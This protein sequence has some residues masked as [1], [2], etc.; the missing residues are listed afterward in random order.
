MTEIPPV[1]TPIMN[2]YPLMDKYVAKIE[3]D[4]KDFTNK[5]SVT[6]V[7][8][9]ET[10]VIL[11]RSPSM[12]N[13]FRFLANFIVPYALG[14]LGYGDDDPIHF[15]TFDYNAEYRL[16]SKDKLLNTQMECRGYTTNMGDAIKK[17]ESVMKL[18]KKNNIRI[19]V[20]SDGEVMDQSTTLMRASKISHLFEEKNVS[21]RAIRFITSDTGA[22]DTRAIS[23]VLQYNT[24][25]D[26]ALV[27]VKAKG[28]HA[29]EIGST[30]QSLFVDDGLDNTTKLEIGGNLIRTEPWKNTSESIYLKKGTNVFWL[31]K[32]PLQATIKTN[33]GSDINYKVRIHD[34]IKSL[35]FDGVLGDKLQ[36]L[37]Q[38]M[39]LYKVVNTPE[40]L[41]EIKTMVGYF[42]RLDDHCKRYDPEL[43]DPT[44]DTSLS[45]RLTYFRGLIKKKE[46]SILNTMLNIAGDNRVNA[47]NSSQQAGYLRQ[48]TNDK[49]GKQ[50]AKR[51]T[52][53]GL[54]LDGIARKEA[55]AI[56]DHFDEL[57]DMDCDDHYKSFY[58]QATTYDGLETVHDAV[59]DG[60]IDEM[61][62]NDILQLLNIVGLPCVAKIGD[63]PDPM[64]YRTQKIIK[65]SFASISDLIVNLECNRK[66]LDPIHKEEIV[67]VIPI[68]DDIEIYNFIK[69]YAP[70]LLEYT[71][72]IGMRRMI[73]DVPF[74]FVHTV[75]SGLWILTEELHNN[76]IDLNFDLFEKLLKPFVQSA[77]PLFDWVTPFLKDQDPKLSYYIGNNGLTNMIQPMSVKSTEGDTSNFHRILSALF[78]FESYQ[79][80]RKMYK[81]MDDG[82][83]RKR[84]FVNDL[85]GID[86]NKYG[87]KLPDH[88]KQNNDPVFYDNYH[89]NNEMFDKL[90]ERLTYVNYGPFLHELIKHTIT[91]DNYS[92]WKEKVMGKDYTT[93]ESI[94]DSLKIYFDVRLFKYFCIV[95]SII[96]DSKVKRTDHEQR[97]MIICDCA[98][99][100]EATKMI[101]NYISNEYKQE[102]IKRINIKESEEHQMLMDELVTSMLNTDSLTTFN[103]SFRDGITRGH[104]TELIRDTYSSGYKPLKEGLMDL[105][106]DVPQRINKFR[107][108]LLGIDDD[109]EVVWN[110]GN[111]LRIN[112]KPIKQFYEDTKNIDKWEYVRETYRKKIKH[113]YQKTN[114]HGHDNENPSFFAM[115]Y[116]TLE[117]F[118]NGSPK[119]EWIDY[120]YNHM[121]CCGVPRYVRYHGA[122]TGDWVNTKDV[123]EWLDKQK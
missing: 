112:L 101:K 50:L 95:Q 22:P 72:S 49:L 81:G 123:E 55:H 21:S 48:A 117:G 15:I 92:E 46:G 53:T 69:K 11:D 113:H 52:K 64:C 57:E 115:G 61:S 78:S 73:I 94:K 76:R 27:D 59:E 91:H 16:M 47:M 34:P 106:K 28:S 25:G 58:S 89:I 14:L 33:T 35:Q 29:S 8:N 37:M 39:K 107:V 97:K 100:E 42:K 108:L 19:L 85:L 70:T 96:F 120:M 2:I 88:Y 114:R 10:I 43:I 63:Y 80:T 65:G 31:D 77:K 20:V 116:E 109:N 54:D 3:Y 122:N 119:D 1:K 102:Y 75:A 45:A 68:F 79:S 74:T 24:S 67:N 5:D 111:V 6:D 104:V 9:I 51:A 17:L 12:G 40:S 60:S 87:T 93:D 56:Y 66:L 18:S 103:K 121:D 41:D 13:N 44:K 38:R 83:I 98:N 7:Q 84:K 23:S 90:L 62:V 110:G 36:Q 32:V 86:F 99:Y 4:S 71:S 105:T 26:V 30:I 82:Y 118:I